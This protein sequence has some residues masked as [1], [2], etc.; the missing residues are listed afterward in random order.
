MKNILFIIAFIFI[1]GN[2]IDA[3]GIQFDKSEWKS[4]LTKAEKENKLVFVDA[5]AAWCGPCKKMDRD[6]F[7]KKEVGDYFN[8]KFVKRLNDYISIHIKWNAITILWRDYAHCWWS[9]VLIQ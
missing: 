1:I 3:Q 2:N 6:V 9:C 4:I 8:A 5:Y 7:S